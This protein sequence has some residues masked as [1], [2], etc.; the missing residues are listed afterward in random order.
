MVIKANS[1]ISK[2]IQ[3]YCDNCGISVWKFLSSTVTERLQKPLDFSIAE[4]EEL[5][6]RKYERNAEF[7]SLYFGISDTILQEKLRIIKEEYGI[8]LS[9][10]FVHIIAEKLSKSGYSFDDKSL[11]KPVRKNA[12]NPKKRKTYAEKYAE[13]VSELRD[14]LAKIQMRKK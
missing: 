14:S 2:A 12:I 8:P 11:R 1:G 10:F 6:Q 4:I 13:S 7:E 5:N 3:N 9:R